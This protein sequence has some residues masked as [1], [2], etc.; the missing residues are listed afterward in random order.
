MIRIKYL[1]PLEILL[2]QLRSDPLDRFL[3][4]RYLSLK[5]IDTTLFSMAHTDLPCF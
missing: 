4:S 1:E 5:S 2:G 3:N